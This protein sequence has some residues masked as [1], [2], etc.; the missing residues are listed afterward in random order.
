MTPRFSDTAR[1]TGS[2]LL[3]LQSDERLVALSRDGNEVAFAAIVDRYRPAL[4][5]HAERIVGPSRAEDAV[6]QAFVNAHRTMLRDDREI[7]L[8]AWLHTITHNAALNLLRT[9]RNE[10]QLDDETFGPPATAMAATGAIEEVVELRA[11]LRETLDRIAGLPAPQRDAILLRELEGRSHDEI[12]LALGVTSGAARQHLMRARNALRTAATAI[13]PYPLVWRLTVSMAQG[14][15]AARSATEVAAAAGVGAGAMKLTAGLAAAG[16]LASAIAIPG[17]R[18]EAPVQR[19]PAT[20]VQRH[21]GAVADDPKSSEA[22][23]PASHRPSASPRKLP[24]APRRRVPARL[25]A[26]PE[27]HHLPGDEAR[28]KAVTHHSG[29][30]V[31]SDEDNGRDRTSAQDDGG[32]DEHRESDHEHDARELST[33]SGSDSSGH[34]AESDSSGSGS[35]STEA[36]EQLDYGA[37]SGD[38]TEWDH[39]TSSGSGSEVTPEADTLEGG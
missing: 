20:V 39:G 24:I 26:R 33:S 11:R 13:T 14:T 4:E 5:R 25:R 23:I 18:P 38:A 34:S 28:T 12:A 2:R 21:A 31:P 6:Q 9:V 16:A 10:I 3:R 37:D 36:P 19:T 30:P 17:I 29:A 8:Q 1:L 15:D 22:I 27:R 32:R 35:G 7:Q